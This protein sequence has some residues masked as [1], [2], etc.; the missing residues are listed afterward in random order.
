MLDGLDNNSNLVDFLNGTAYAIR[1]PIDAIQEFK[2]Q[3]SDYSAELGRSAGAVLNA[4]IKSGT[5]SFHGSVWEFFRNDK[6][7]AANFFENSG[8]L[9]KGKFRQNQFGVSA[10]GPIRKNKTFIF[11]DYEGTRIRQAIPYVAT[12]PTLQV[13]NSGYT[14]LSELLNQ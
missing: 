11:G 5:N 13:R 2:I 10:G 14:D 1:P 8:G 7:D 9:K 12:V 6:L 3:T 4:T